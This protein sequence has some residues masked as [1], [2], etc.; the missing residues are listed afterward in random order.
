MTAARRS[1]KR[2]VRF[3]SRLALALGLAIAAHCGALRAA[4]TERIVVDR[5]TGLALYGIDPVGYFTDGKPVRGREE[6]EYTYAGATWRFENE[7]NRAAFAADPDVYM[8]RYG[9]YDP[10]GIARGLATAGS[11]TLWV[12]FE[13]RLYLFYTADARATFIGD[14]PTAIAA[15]SARWAAVKSE[16]AE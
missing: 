15:A 14:P 12:V 5:H 8:P 7:G 10:L 2:H 3:A 4:T 13:Q 1:R 11:P 16:L 9:G 6:F